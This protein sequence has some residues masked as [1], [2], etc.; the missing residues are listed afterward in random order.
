[1]RKATEVAIR[2]Q[3]RLD[4]VTDAEGRDPSIMNGSTSNSRLLQ[5]R[6]ERIKETFAFSQ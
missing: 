3:E 4:A 2:R 5:Q 6:L 1:L